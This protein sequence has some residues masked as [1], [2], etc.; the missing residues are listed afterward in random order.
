L[1]AAPAATA[2]WVAEALTG[3]SEGFPCKLAAMPAA[4]A[5]WVGSLTEGTDGI[6]SELAAAAAGASGAAT[7]STVDISVGSVDKVH[8]NPMNAT[9]DCKREY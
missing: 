6:A 8:I 1:A 7:A 3:G 4:G 5:S 2:F 9:S